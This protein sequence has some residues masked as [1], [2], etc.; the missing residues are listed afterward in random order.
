MFEQEFYSKE[1][2]IVDTNLAFKT[3]L[4]VVYPVSM[5]LISKAAN[6]AIADSLALS[7]F[8]VSNSEKILFPAMN[9]NMYHNQSFF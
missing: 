4:I 6:L 7:V 3:N 9:H 5:S 1:D 2:L 8:L